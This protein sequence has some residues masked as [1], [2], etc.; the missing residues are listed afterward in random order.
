MS[1]LGKK[2]DVVDGELGEIHVAAMAPAFP[3]LQQPYPH[4]AA[5]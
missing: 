4:L 2:V 5:S 3:V 1:E